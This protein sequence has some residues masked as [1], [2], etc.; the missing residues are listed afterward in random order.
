MPNAVRV[1]ITRTDNNLRVRIYREGVDMISKTE[2]ITI[3]DAND[4]AANEFVCMM[5]EKYGKD[6]ATV[7]VNGVCMAGTIGQLL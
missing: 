4:T 2:V 5:I 1:D 6:G 3:K 7:A